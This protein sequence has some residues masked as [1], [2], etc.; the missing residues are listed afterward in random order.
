MLDNGAL[1]I[2]KYQVLKVLGQGGMSTVYL[3]KE[4]ISSRRITIKEIKKE[5][6]SAVDTLEAE[7]L[8]KLKH[9][10]IPALVDCFH[11]NKRMCLVLEYIEGMTLENYVKSQ[12]SISMKQ[13][14][15]IML[16][17]CSITEYLHTLKPAVIYR[18]LKPSN[19][20]ITVDNRVVLI[21]YGSARFYKPERERDTVYMASKGY[22][23]PEQY[24][25]G[26]SSVRTDVYGL[27]AVLYFMMKKRAPLNLLEPLRSDLYQGDIENKLKHIIQNSMQIDEMKRYSS[28][29]D[30]KQDLK[31][32][33]SEKFVRRST[34]F[35]NA[36]E[37]SYEKTTL[38]AESESKPVY[39]RYM[40]RRL[41]I[42]GLFFLVLSGIV[43]PVSF[44]R[45][46]YSKKVAAYEDR[47]TAA[48]EINK[49]NE[50]SESI[51]LGEDSGQ[52]VMQYAEELH[53]GEIA[54]ESI[55]AEE[56]KRADLKTLTKDPEPAVSNKKAK[57][58]N[59]G[60]KGKSKGKNRK[61]LLLTP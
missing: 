51:Y 10:G 24:G 47:L 29:E 54:E 48:G 4:V 5:I 50:G 19:I 11:E 20:M 58:G 42:A 34:S 18:D 15:H 31:L 60:A 46:R 38:I 57:P 17:L 33:L 25:S 61:N 22:A 56:V 3:G 35:R 23:A 28:V 45:H 7:M 30:M 37:D 32:I 13:I 36:A 59:S 27:G 9:P 44:F 8:K 41:I 43:L 49:E 16:S 6:S 14:G 53:Q 55:E 26:Q 40:N 21:D 2:G 1:L 12:E 39:K 52:D